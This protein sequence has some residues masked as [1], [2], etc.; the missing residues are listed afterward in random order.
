MKTFTITIL[1]PAAEVYRHSCTAEDFAISG[2]ADGASIIEFFRYGAEEYSRVKVCT[3]LVPVG[4]GYILPE[5][6]HA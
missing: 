6:E 4:F 1:P 2:R 5:F 3:I